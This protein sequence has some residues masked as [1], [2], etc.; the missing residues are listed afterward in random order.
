MKPKTDAQIEV[1]KINNLMKET[2]SIN[3]MNII[4]KKIEKNKK[5]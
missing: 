1:V 4:I 3:D 5:Y 2:I